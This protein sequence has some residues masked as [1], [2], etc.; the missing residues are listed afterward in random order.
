M[1]DREAQQQLLG[2]ISHMQRT[3]KWMYQVALPSECSEIWFIAP[4][5]FEIDSI[6][7]LKPRRYSAV[8]HIVRFQ[9]RELPQL[10]RDIN[11]TGYGLTLGIHS[12]IDET[13][14]LITSTAH[15]GNISRQS[16]HRWCSR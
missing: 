10:I 8:L 12:R 2:H 6:R 5:L 11:A 14:D 4:T 9:S 3:A 7:E 1:I 13:I 15:V 16:Q